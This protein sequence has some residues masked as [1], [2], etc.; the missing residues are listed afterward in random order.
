MKIISIIGARPNFMKVAPLHRAF[1]QLSN[2]T[3][4][5]VHT[6]QHYD[7]RM[8]DIF[9]NQLEL[10]KPDYY[11]GVVSGSQ[12]RQTAD[13]MTKFEDVLLVEKPDWVVVVGDVTSTIACALV[14]VRNGVRV[15]HVEA[16]LRSGDRKMPEEINRILTDNLSDLLF[17]T[18]QAGLDNLQR[19]GVSREKVHFVGNVMID[20][21]VYYRAQAT[22]LDT[23]G[24]LGLTPKQYVLMTMHRPS[25]V[26]LP[27]GLRAVVQI[28]ADTAQH[29]TVV[30]PLHP[31]TAA[32]L[33][34]FE[35]MDK[36]RA[37]PNVR[38]LEPQG[39]LEFLNLMEHATAV[40]T[41]SG[42]IQEETT[43]LQVPCLTLRNSTERPSTVEMGT[44]TLLANF[45]PAT[46]RHHL[47]A[48]QANRAKQGS[49]PPL[50]DGQTANRIAS[51]LLNRSNP[52]LVSQYTHLVYVSL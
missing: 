31:R 40:I 23:V 32:N 6:G 34:R 9:F 52:Q 15:A 37:I 29:Q 25:N 24:T 43:Y 44:N 46:V 5:I 39:Y 18:E 50:W 7:S 13:I 48:I 3:S 11:L 14:A 8:S 16:G 17:I 4:K 22:A 12:T 42:G 47:T 30:V 19:E 1:Q 33:T 10:P 51:I 2:V 26:D 38:L 49:I 21:L 35:L 28:V 36:L 41:D 20:S 27:D 45:N